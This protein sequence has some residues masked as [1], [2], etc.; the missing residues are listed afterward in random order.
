VH[1]VVRSI[2]DLFWEAAQLA[3]GE[4]RDAFLARACGGD[5]ELRQRVER[6][7][8]AQAKVG[9][10][11][12]RP[13]PPPAQLPTVDPLPAEGPGTMIGPYRLLEQI[14]EG[15]MGLVFMAE[16]T[17]P[18][19][20]KV[21][22]KVL[23]PGMDTRQVVARFEAERQALALMD[24]PNIAKVFDGGTTGEPAASAAGYAAPGAVHPAANAAGSPGRPYFVME[25]VRGVAITE[26]CDQHRLTTRQRLELFVTVCQAVQH[27][28]QKGIIHRDLKP[29]NVLVTL[30]D[31]MAVPKVIDFGI[32]KA[33]SGPLTERTLFTH[34][35]QMI[36]T[37]L[38]MS[39]EQA[40]MNGLDVDTRSDVYAL[41]VLLYELLTGTTPFTTE[42]LRRAGLD[43]MRR[44]IREEEP[45]T[46]SQRLNTLDAQASTT[47]A[48]RRGVD[49]RRLGQVLR[50]EL[51]WIVMRA[52]EKDRN[53]RYE[54][55]SAFAADVQRY[56]S[57]EAVSACPPSAGY[58]LRK[59]VRRYRR[60][61]LTAGVIAGALMA[62]TGVSIWQ[63]ARATEAQHQA[64]TDRDRARTAEGQAKTNLERAKE[65]EQRA[66]TE[67]A[68]AKAV[69][70]FLGDLFGQA[71][72]APPPGREFTE[73][74]YL[75]VKE[76][77]DRA[78]ARI[79]QRF[80]DQPLVEAAIGMA[81]GKAYNSLSD[82][83]RAVPHFERAL[84][85]RKAHLGPADPGTLDSMQALS[86]AYL[87]AGRHSES[88]ALRH[89]LLEE[90]RARLGPDHPEVLE[91]M[92]ALADAYRWAS[93]LDMSRQ[94]FEEVLEKRRILFGPTHRATLDIM[95][96][97]GGV[98]EAAGR[99]EEAIH[100]NVKILEVLK[101]KKESETEWAYSIR[102]QIARSCMRVG[103]FDQADRLLREVL[104]YYQNRDDS[105]ARGFGLATSGGWLALSLVLQERYAEAVPIAREAAGLY[106][107]HAPNHARR[108]YYEGVLGAALLGQKKYA[109][110][111]PV[112]LQ[113]YQG[114]KRWERMSP[115]VI[116][117][118]AEVVGWIVKLYEA[119]NQPEKARAW[120]EKLKPKPPDA[121]SAGA[122]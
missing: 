72:S 46:P 12:E 90:R 106:A 86:G 11:L 89:Q 3:P 81:I 55:A 43:E 52:L 115:L 101:A 19:R 29:S 21:A 10:F 88:I 74:P 102:I 100:L 80:Q 60:P 119:T 95:T 104:Q 37:P 23:K 85:L 61:L 109:E 25:L 45:P 92:T 76:A 70:D 8:Q 20:R 18:V 107:K 38:Y 34:F 56:L 84:A 96:L 63:A 94:L 6:L 16:Q 27:A 97:L 62:A 120:R 59:F 77:L 114:M 67:A 71:A 54:S 57:D 36:G 105:H 40:E 26:F 31:T 65:A 41:G 113:A 5:Q 47:V 51:D 2:D 44:I 78:E 79:G 73:D 49:G 15:G 53:R 68:S 1:N 111:E 117:G 66:T 42:A 64:E 69:S 83:G 91:C 103:R 17:Q 58:R 22:L 82:P 9:D 39:P 48:E 93:Q 32:A 116:S 24:H 122:K 50:G 7:L 28:H 75:T 99:F 118:M 121:A 112:L 33:T 110:A 108:F 30:H 4:P 13:F 14:G 98:H 35:A 87:W